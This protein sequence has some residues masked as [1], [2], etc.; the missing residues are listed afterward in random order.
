MASDEVFEGQH[1]IRRLPNRPLWVDKFEL[2]EKRVKET[3]EEIVTTRKCI[4]YILSQVN[5]ANESIT[6]L[7]LGN[8]RRLALLGELNSKLGLL[9]DKRDNDSRDMLELIPKN[10]FYNFEHDY[11]NK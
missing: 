9:T 7:F 11:L 10:V 5:V 6:S 4:D 1:E 8:N 3:N 2:L